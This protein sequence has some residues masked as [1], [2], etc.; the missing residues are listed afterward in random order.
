MTSFM[1]EHIKKKPFYKKPWFAKTAGILFLAIIFGAVSAIIF[2]LTLPWA[3]ENFGNPEVYSLGRETTAETTN[4]QTDENSVQ[5]SDRKEAESNIDLEDFKV[6]YAQIRDIAD[7]AF[8]GVVTVSGISSNEDLF[9]KVYESEEKASGMIV[10]MDSS[11]IL[12]LT[13]SGI[14]EDAERIIIRLADDTICEAQ[15][16]MTDEVSELALLTVKREEL[17]EEQLNDMTVLNFGTTK[18]LSQ[19]D[20]II[21]L[22]NLMEEMNSIAS[23][24]VTSLGDTP[25]MDDS[26]QIIH[27]DIAGSIDGSGILL[28]MDGNVVGIMTHKFG[29]NMESRICAIAADDISRILNQMMSGEEK[30]VMGIT[31]RNVTENISEELNMPQGLYVT[32]V[33]DNSPAMYYGIQSGDILTSMNGEKILSQK[34]YQNV[35]KQCTIGEEIP[36]KI[37]R[38]VRDGYSEMEMTVRLE[39][40]K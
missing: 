14:L 40:Q 19:G 23:G 7:N 39:E 3:Q 29:T 36:I 31:G 17:E 22:G 6:L 2:S 27:T 13:Q 5:T 25:V 1:K 10:G 21:A 32:S 12:I 35:L 16:I 8:H 4:P 37:M 15:L 9:Q 18:S 20:P 33:A 34:D 28:D 30:V 11:Q 24:A 26:Y 38:K